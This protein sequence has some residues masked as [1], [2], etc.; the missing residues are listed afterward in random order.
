M[1]SSQK[2]P[3][4]KRNF[5]LGVFRN[6]QG[7]Q[8]PYLILFQ[9]F[10]NFSFTLPAFLVH[11]QG[12]IIRKVMETFFKEGLEPYFP[13]FIKGLLIF[14]N[15]FPG[16]PGSLWGFLFTPQGRLVPP[17]F[18]LFKIPSF[19]KGVLTKGGG[20]SFFGN[21]FCPIQGKGG[22]QGL[23][24]P[25]GKVFPPFSPFFPLFFPKRN[26]PRWGV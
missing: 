14:G 11:K 8:L 10:P 12:Q 25:R 9:G 13:L 15:Y 26:L 21:P 24:G 3:Q 17:F 18:S 6:P 7:S 2:K 16:F 23:I 4:K 5:N 20:N 22:I 19:F 1:G